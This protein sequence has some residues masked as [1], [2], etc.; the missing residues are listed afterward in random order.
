MPDDIAPDSETESASGACSLGCAS[1][2]VLAGIL[3]PL[4]HLLAGTYEPEILFVVF[5]VGGPSF[6]VAHGFAIAALNSKSKNT[7]HLGKRS[8]QVIWGSVAIFLVILL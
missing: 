2:F 5:A 3:W 6:L 1:L 4:L 8:L 7:R